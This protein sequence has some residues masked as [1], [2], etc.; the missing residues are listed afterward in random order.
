M[1]YRRRR[2]FVETPKGRRSAGFSVPDT[3]GAADVSLKLRERG[4]TPYALRL[5]PEQ[6][7]WVALVMDWRRAA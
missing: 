1:P 2:V 5:E 4:W 7:T 6:N 3:A